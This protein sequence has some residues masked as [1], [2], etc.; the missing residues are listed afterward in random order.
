MWG[1]LG[2]TAAVL[3]GAITAAI[4]WEAMS[5]GIDAEIEK[6]EAKRRAA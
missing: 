1:V 5:E 4:V 3:A 6:N 2:K